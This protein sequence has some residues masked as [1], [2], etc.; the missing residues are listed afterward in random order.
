MRGRRG[1]RTTS[2][3]SGF[4]RPTLAKVGRLA[5]NEVVGAPTGIM[6]Q[7]ASLLGEPDSAVF[8][9]CRSLDAEVIPL[10][11]RRRPA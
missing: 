8:L 1:P 5:E 10:G 6:D 7:T 9:D 3:A 4:D 2:G 11:L